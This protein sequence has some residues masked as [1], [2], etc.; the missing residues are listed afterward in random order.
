MGVDYS[1]NY[2]IGFKV[3]PSET[4]RDTLANKDSYILEYIDEILEDKY[5]YFEVGDASY[6]GGENT[7]Y[8]V[9]ADEKTP[10]NLI[11]S[12]LDELENLLT[13]KDLIVSE[14]GLV[15]GLNIW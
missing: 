10:F 15:G 8:V 7:V 12:E 13:S 2:G 1:A 9:L 4:L 6:T 14:R 3:E 5:T 11:D